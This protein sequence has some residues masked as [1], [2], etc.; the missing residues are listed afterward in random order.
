MY[1]ILLLTEDCELIFQPGLVI[2]EIMREE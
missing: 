2:Y 1:S